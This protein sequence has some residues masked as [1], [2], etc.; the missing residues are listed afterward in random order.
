MRPELLRNNASQSPE[1]FGAEHH[2]VLTALP[3]RPPSVPPA[4]PQP[5]LE[6]GAYKTCGAAQN[7]WDILIYTSSASRGAQPESLVFR[8]ND[9]KGE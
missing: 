3:E 6:V 4:H 9:A 5:W 7:V 8:G 1:N 2:M